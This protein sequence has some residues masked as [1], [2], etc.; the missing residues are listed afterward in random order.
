MKYKNRQRKVCVFT[1]TRAEYGLLKLLMQEIVNTE[2]VVLQIIASCMHL[3]PEFGLTY[4]EIEED[5]FTIDEKVEMLLSSDSP[6]GTGKSIGLGIISFCEVLA[7]LKPDIAVILGDRFEAL[8]MAIASAVSKIPVAHIH[9]G[10]VTVGALDEAF[11]HSITKMSHLHFTSTEEYRSRVI[12]LGEH[13]KRVFNVGAPGV[14]SIRRLK[15]LSR[16]SLEEEL[17]I[18]FNKHNLLITYHPITLEKNRSRDHF[19]AILNTVDELRDTNMI[20][21]K[22]NADMYGRI[23]NR[24]IDEYVAGNS[25]KAF[26]FESLGQ[27]NYL[28]LMKQMD[29]VFGNSSSGIIEAPSFNIGT[30]NIGDRQ[31]GRIR[32]TSVIDCDPDE[33]SLRKALRRLYSKRFQDGLST[34]KNPYKKANT[35]KRIVEVIKRF[36]LN[37]IVKKKFYDVNFLI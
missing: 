33:E 26:S 29:A 13:P 2:G 24:L 27:L 22:A 12:Q 10:E 16:K 7:R 20:F 32:S 37:G 15:F 21:T 34:V 8:G 35:A 25:H 3:S 9:G 18:R 5:G 14:D 1:G 36:D 23:I 11:R 31:M 28:S 30:I 6:I 17:N 19:Q 4:R